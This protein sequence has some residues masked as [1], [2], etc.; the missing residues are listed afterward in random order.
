MEELPQLGGLCY[1]VEEFSFI[2][3][4]YKWS[5]DPHSDLLKF[6]FSQLYNDG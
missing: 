3:K 5:H 2:W 4:L 1:F 6:Y